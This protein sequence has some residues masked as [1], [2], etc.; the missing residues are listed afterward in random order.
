MKSVVL[1]QALFEES[2]AS[3]KRE[4]NLKT[5]IKKVQKGYELRLTMLT[6]NNERGVTL[7]RELVM[8]KTASEKAEEKNNKLLEEKKSLEMKFQS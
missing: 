1:V 7:E 4:G 5:E 3:S 8:A 6:S 2:N